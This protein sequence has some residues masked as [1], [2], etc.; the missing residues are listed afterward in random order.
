[1]K[2]QKWGAI[3][4]KT[5]VF[6]TSCTLMVGGLSYTPAVFYS[7]PA[8]ITAEALTCNAPS[9][10]AWQQDSTSRAQIDSYLTGVSYWN[11]H[12][13]TSIG[14]RN[15]TIGSSA[16]GLF[17]VIN[18]VFYKTGNFMDPTFVAD[19]S[20]ANGYRTANNGVDTRFF[21]AY[22]QN[23]GSTYGF[24]YAGSYSSVSSALEHVRNGGTICGCVPGHWIAIVDYNAS[25]GK[26]LMLD[27]SR[28][29][30]RCSSIGGWSGERGV[31]W[32]SGSIFSSGKY[33][34]SGRCMY[35]LSYSGS[36]PSPVPDTN[37]AS[38]SQLPWNYTYPTR[39]LYQKSPMMNGN[40]VRWLQSALSYLGYACTVDGY[41]GAETK[42]QIR[43]YQSANG[44]SVDGKAGTK[45]LSSLKAKAEAKNN[46]SSD[47]QTSNNSNYGTPSRTLRY[48]KGSLM[49]GD[50]VK[51]LQASLN[52]LIHAGL[53][54]DGMFGKNTYNAVK[55]FQSLNSLG[56][57]GIVGIYTRGKL[58]ALLENKDYVPPQSSTGTILRYGY[59]EPSGN[60]KSGSKGDTVRWLQVAL[61][62][63]MSSGLDIDGHY[64]PKTKA[65]VQSFQSQ[66]G[67][68]ADGIFGNASRAKMKELLAARSITICGGSEEPTIAELQL[69]EQKYYFAEEESIA[70]EFDSDTADTYHL[71]IRNEE[72]GEVVY[73]YQT[74][75]YSLTTALNAGTYT[76]T[77]TVSNDKGSLTSDPISFAVIQ[78]S[79]KDEAISQIRSSAYDTALSYN[80]KTDKLYMAEDATYE[81]MW[82]FISHEN[83]TFE[84]Y[85]A[86]YGKM[87][88]ISDGK[89]KMVD[90]NPEDANAYWYLYE[91][92]GMSFIKNMNSD[93]TITISS[94]GEIS[95]EALDTISD[96]QSVSFVT[97]NKN[98]VVPTFTQ[99]DATHAKLSWNP[100][101]GCDLYT[102]T[103]FDTDGVTEDGIFD[104]IETTDTSCEIEIPENA[105]YS[106]Y[107]EASVA[108]DTIIGIG[109]GEDNE[110]PEQPEQPPQEEPVDP[111]EQY[112]TKVIQLQHYLLNESGYSVSELNELDMDFDGTLTALDL[113]L[114]K[115]MILSD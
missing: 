81:S 108:G 22:S 65:A 98:T 50:D 77:V 45:T 86:Y 14:S 93:Q 19:W 95:L 67:L 57:D 31:A 96:A 105:A 115:K 20:K 54:V 5:M 63:T 84:I 106:V 75:E 4:K 48:T 39:T 42:N 27:S 26:Y 13:W 104:Y 73:D 43:A 12:L 103:I 16:C 76:A 70:F 85:N 89:L 59:S 23:Y 55:N 90:P 17:S 100:V 49:R 35:G 97:D 66:N 36:R 60:L 9:P 38:D 3:A 33:T 83:W 15:Q 78:Q 52:Q 29:S 34:L 72:N 88:T 46:G 62:N 114:L 109:V 40:D 44:L 25:T 32:V 82:R 102:V 111:S 64:G 92:D 6:L 58:T 79:E 80:L 113:V 21:K 107:L 112:L 51:W 28:A 99:I 2:K 101:E 56:V 37:T 74:D 30:S 53:T 71:V 24:S 94:D 8:A 18:S 68:K 10:I 41:L 87:L 69:A 110:T 11:N 47:G 91:E 7:D 61:N 1:M